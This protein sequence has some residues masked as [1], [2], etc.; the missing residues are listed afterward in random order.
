MT[1]TCS[2]ILLKFAL[3]E[4]TGYVWEKDNP[5]NVRLIVESVENEC[6]RVKSLPLNHARSYRCDIRRC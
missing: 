3:F 6:R 1:K 5:L 2:R 4:N